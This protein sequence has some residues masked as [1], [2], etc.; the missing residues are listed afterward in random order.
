VDL[1][2]GDAVTFQYLWTGTGAL[3]GPLVAAV[4]IQLLST[5]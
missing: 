2:A 1:L 5:P 3:T 4:S